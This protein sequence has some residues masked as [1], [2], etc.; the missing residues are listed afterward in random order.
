[1]KDITR[2]GILSGQLLKNAS[3]QEREILTEI[4]QEIKP[5][6]ISRKFKDRKHKKHYDDDYDY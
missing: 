4:A 5:S 3:E 1:M 6:R 2:N